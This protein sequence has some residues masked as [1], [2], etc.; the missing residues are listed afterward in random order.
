MAFTGSLTFEVGNASQT[1]RVSASRNDRAVTVRAV[2]LNGLVDELKL[3]R[4][5]FIKMDIEGAERTRSQVRRGCWPRTS[6]GWPSASTMRLTIRKSCR[7]WCSRPTTT[8]RRSTAA[9]FRRISI[10]RRRRSG[11]MKSSLG[12][13]LGLAVVVFAPRPCRRRPVAGFAAGE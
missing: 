7:A 6:R 5:D 8:M 2:T 12:N 1:G 3:N 13:V 4:V 9:D 11:L 10:E